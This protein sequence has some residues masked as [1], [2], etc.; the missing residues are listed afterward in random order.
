MIMMIRRVHG[1]SCTCCFSSHVFAVRYMYVIHDHVHVH[2]RNLRVR[3]TSV[4]RGKK[5]FDFVRIAIGFVH[6]CFLEASFPNSLLAP[7]RPSPGGAPNTQLYVYHFFPRYQTLSGHI[8]I[9]KMIRNENSSDLERAPGARS[10]A[11]E[12]LLRIILLSR[13]GR[14]KSETRE[15][16]DTHIGSATLPRIPFSLVELF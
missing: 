6:C 15:K 3:S 5:R 8:S 2:V 16:S 11:V 14:S 13:Y 10:I 7:S 4:A 12:F 9:N 1:R